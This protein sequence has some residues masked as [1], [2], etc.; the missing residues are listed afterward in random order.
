MKEDISI[1]NSSSDVFIFA[2][3]TNN[4]YKAPPEQN[5]KRL[6]ENATKTYTKLTERLEKSNRLSIS[7][8][9]KNIAKKLDLVERVKCLAKNT[10]FITL[11]DH[12]ENF[13]AS[14]PC[15]LINPSKS[16]LGKVSLVKLEKVNQALIKH[17]DV[18]QWKKPSSVTEWFKGID[19]KKDCIFIKFDIREFYPSIWE[20]IFKKSILF[21][22][23]HIADEDV[24]TLDHRRKSLLFHENEHW[25]KKKT[26]SCFDMT[27]GSYDGAEI[28][29]L[30]GIYILT[31]RA[32][33]IR[34]SDC[35]LYRDDDLVILRNVNGQQIDRTRKNI[36]K[37]FKDV[38]DI[39]LK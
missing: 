21:V 17:L 30:V 7:L 10:A 28:C 29:E 2:N 35:G 39:A 23:H 34:K 5:K 15:R 9:A 31:R 25:E 26:E 14:L 12:K 19:N 11:K 27:M 4:I 1:I 6:K 20:S 8:E 32:T 36:I 37:I 33:I 3:K 16:E 13:R 22:N 38:S 18:N 24:R